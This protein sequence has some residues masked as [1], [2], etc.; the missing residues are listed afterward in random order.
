M[1]VK[2]GGG[3]KIDVEATTDQYVR[4][5]NKAAKAT[6]KHAKAVEKDEK[7]LKQVGLEYQIAQA[8]AQNLAK[9]YEDFGKALDKSRASM[10]AASAQAKAHSGVLAQLGKRLNVDIVGG[11]M[12]VSSAINIGKSAWNVLG[13]GAAK[14]SE[15]AAQ[16]TAVSNVMGN[17][18]F[19]LDKARSA[20]SGLVKDMDLAKAA[21][22]LVSTGVVDNAQ[23]FA[24]LA[25]AAQALGG[26]IGIDSTQAFD[27]LTAALARGST[28][29][30]DNLG[31]VVKQ[32]QATK[33]YAA[34]LGKSVSAMT[35]AEKG[36]AFREVAMRKIIE[37]ARGI[38]V[39]TDSAGAAVQRF[40]ADLDRLQNKA[41]GGAT[42]QITL[43]KGLEKVAGE[44]HKNA[45]EIAAYGNEA[46]KLRDMLSDVNV[47]TDDL[48]ITNTQL[49]KEL[50][51][52]RR[53]ELARLE[54]LIGTGEITDENVK[55]LHELRTELRK[56]ITSGDEYIDTLIE[57][58]EEQDL[59]DR[60]ARQALEV[61]H[62]NIKSSIAF[63]QGKGDEQEILNASVIEE[64]E[65]RAKILDMEGQSVQAEK[66]RSE[67]VL[68]RARMQGQ[69]LRRSGGGGRGRRDKAFRER[70]ERANFIA[71]Q[72]FERR[73]TLA[74]LRH[75]INARRK[76]QAEFESLDPFSEINLERQL[77]NVIDFEERRAEVEL[78]SRMRGIEAQRAAGVEPLQLIEN[79]ASAR[80][81]HAEAVRAAEER[82]LEREI[83]LAEEQNRTADA[84]LLRA[85]RE[86]SAV[87]HQGQIEEIEHQRHMARLAEQQKREKFVHGEKMRLIKMGA[88]VTL[89]AAAAVARAT[90]LEGQSL[91][92]SVAGVAKSLAFEHTLKAASEVVNAA[93]A[94]AS[95]R[96][97]A[98]AQHSANALAAAGVAATAGAVAAAAGVGGSGP[99]ASGGGFA[100]AGAFG[101]GGGGA[102]SVP[103]GTS[104]RSG[105]LGGPV[106]I[107]QTQR[108]RV[109]AEAASAGNGQQ[110][111]V[112]QNIYVTTTGTID[113]ETIF[114]IEDGQ[115]RAASRFGR[116]RTG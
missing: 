83:I 36:E 40:E 50:D 15:L 115:R 110:T 17:L 56:N 111:V 61:E 59:A 90:I 48:A 78:S 94:A 80:L 84:R 102:G 81:E 114:K 18:P 82:R 33:E 104:A 38:K 1:T 14:I 74:T 100:S 30:L 6:D 9:R 89:N 20:T 32:E 26:R 112:N 66:L 16:S 88:D 75:N 73:E 8:R 28:E 93:I 101:P 109:S 68:A 21:S 58:R 43:Q 99:G 25:Q 39:D 108:S 2:Q 23:D 51:K 87:E 49:G 113:D 95:Y 5:M 44:F 60:Q 19:S 13:D 86:I 106:P 55:R 3:I 62:E 27:S 42:S 96:Y 116:V 37:A 97:D 12:A 29:M 63:L 107:S 35:D 11:L 47:S 31:I 10:A 22:T 45:G 105:D 103:G 41:L 91:K 72:E 67:I 98:A 54:N 92:K 46:D 65:I 85:E 69:A 71:Q 52:V 70:I 53:M 79:E 57:R 4:E 34:T 76:A 7:A 64:M 24:Q 77:T